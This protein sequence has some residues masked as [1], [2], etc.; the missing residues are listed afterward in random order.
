MKDQVGV[1]LAYGYDILLQFILPMIPS[2]MALKNKQVA[3]NTITQSFMK[4]Q[5]PFLRVSES[6]D[7]FFLYLLLGSIP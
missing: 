4:L 2:E 6:T 7:E 5:H 3:A 1:A